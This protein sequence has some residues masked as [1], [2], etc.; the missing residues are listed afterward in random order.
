MISGGFDAHERDSLNEGYGNLNEFDFSWMSEQIVKIA[1]LHCD[2]KIVSVLEGGYGTRGGKISILGECVAYHIRA[3]MNPALQN[4]IIQEKDSIL[5]Q[6][7]NDQL[8]AGIKRTM[9][10]TNVKVMRKR[11]KIDK[12]ITPLPVEGQP[13]DINSNSNSEASKA[14]LKNPDYEL[15]I[16]QIVKGTKQRPSESKRS[17]EQKRK[18]KEEE[19]KEEDSEVENEESEKSYGEIDLSDEESDAMVID[20]SSDS[21]Q[22]HESK[23][24]IIPNL[25]FSDNENH[26]KQP[27]QEPQQEQEQEQEAEEEQEQ[28]VELE[29]QEEREELEEREVEDNK[30]VSLNEDIE[31]PALNN[32]SSPKMKEDKQPNNNNNNNKNPNIIVDNEEDNDEI[33]VVNEEDEDSGHGDD[34]HHNEP[35][36]TVLDQD[37]LEEDFDDNILQQMEEHD[38]PALDFINQQEEL[39]L[40]ELNQPPPSNHNNHNQQL[41][42]SVFSKNQNPNIQEIQQIQQIEQ[43]EQIE[44]I[45]QIYDLE[46]NFNDEEL[47]YDQKL[48]E[49]DLIPFEEKDKQFQ[50]ES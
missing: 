26:N 20:I 19:K 48:N 10:A 22:I 39:E 30:S 7:E 34:I 5:E 50:E 13:I 1:N 2:G 6:H 36:P 35:I 44:Q 21:E 37:P 28:E 17:K 46:L 43:F 11:K 41:Q 24:S 27:E 25:I 23:S 16:Q 38:M 15:F 29:E 14:D 33:E 47:I 12:L 3:L 49:S 9:K 4:Y 31:E 45:E 32:S 40:S 8:L 18:G 42:S